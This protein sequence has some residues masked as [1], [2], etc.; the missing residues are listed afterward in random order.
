MNDMQNLGDGDMKTLGDLVLTNPK[1]GKRE[2]GPVIPQ[3]QTPE[4]K[5]EKIIIAP[6]PDDEVIGC[7]EVLKN[8]NPIIIY[9]ARDIPNA[10]RE[11]ARKI[12]EHFSIKGQFFLSTIPHNLLHQ[13][14]TFFF[15]HPVYETH[16]EHR[17]Q[18][19]VGEQLLRAG[20]PN[21]YFYITEMTA[22]FKFEADPEKREMMDK[23]YSDQKDMWK[24]EHKYF[25]FSGYDKWIIKV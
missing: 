4:L 7:F 20:N 2:D 25:L 18:G 8:Y 5:N 19:I 10:R 22:P 13:S 9:T 11:Q 23:C 21:I 3:Q 16:F 1:S 14:N 24:Y 15:P 12:R 17:M 6:H